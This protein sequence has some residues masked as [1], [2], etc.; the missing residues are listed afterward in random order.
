MLIAQHHV[1]AV[2]ENV[3]LHPS[4]SEQLAGRTDEIIPFD[5]AFQ[6]PV[7]LVD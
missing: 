1:A 4:D 7:V 3:E 6:F 2:V 5:R